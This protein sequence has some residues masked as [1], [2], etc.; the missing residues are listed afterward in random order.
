MQ[1]IPMIDLRELRELLAAHSLPEFWNVLTDQYFS[2]VLIPGSRRV[3]LD[4]VGREVTQRPV[5][6]DTAIVVYCAGPHC[7][8]AGK[9]A[10][11]L[12]AFGFTNVRVYDGG[13]QQWRDAGLD[14]I[15]VE[16]TATAA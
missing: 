14:F 6:K 15:E 12:A 16:R 4:Q 2:G 5:A 8:Q 7:P 13:V 3:P 1:A 9:A 11:K 10:E